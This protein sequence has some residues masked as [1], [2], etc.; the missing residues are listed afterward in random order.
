MGLRR[1]RSFS[2][3]V[4][5][6]PFEPAVLVDDPLEE[7]SDGASFKWTTVHSSSVVKH[8]D[9]PIGLI[10]VQP[11]L[12][13]ETPQRKRARSAVVEE[14]HKLLV[15]FVN[16]TPKPL[17]LI[18]KTRGG[19]PACIGFIVCSIAHELLSSTKFAPF[20]SPL[21]SQRT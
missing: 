20:E 12:F 16:L 13:F 7:T 2:V 8:L 19:A 1:Y 9:F 14:P 15:Q 10:G 18:V 17:H 21:L 11:H 5:R 4:F 3:F 6:Q